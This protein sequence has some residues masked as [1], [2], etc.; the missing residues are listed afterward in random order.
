M[1]R[2]PAAATA[3][4]LLSGALFGAAAVLLGGFVVEGLGEMNFACEG[5]W[6]DGGTV[7][8][9]LLAGAALLAAG[10]AGFVL[11]VEDRAVRGRAAE[12]VVGVN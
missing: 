9:W 6:P 12:S 2:R 3:A 8:W 1:R 7:W 4:V 10:R 5:S 11:A